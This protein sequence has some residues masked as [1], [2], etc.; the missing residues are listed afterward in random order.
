MA[1]R[2][3]PGFVFSSF[4]HV[5]VLGA[6]L[7]SFSSAPKLEE[8]QET[9][10]VEMLTADQF[11]QIMKGDKSAEKPMPKQK[12][13]KLAQVTETKP[14]PPVAEAKQDVPT[15]PPPLKRQVDPGRSDTPEKT[16]DAPAPPPRPTPE[17]PKPVAKTE[18]PKP[19][20]PKP[21]ARPEP[22]KPT[23]P[24][25]E[26]QPDPDDAEPIRP[27]PVPRPKVE[28]AKAEPTPAVKPAPRPPLKEV[29]APKVEARKPDAFK[30]DL[31]AK[32][33][34]EKPADKPVQKP[35]SRPKSGDETAEARRFDLADI[36]Q[37]LSKDIP[38]RRASSGRE[39]Q[40]VA[41]L[42]A[43]TASAAQMSPSLWAALDG[44]M[45]DQYKQCWTYFGLGAHG[46]YVPEIRVQYAQNGGLVGQP[47]LMNPPSDPNLRSL[48]DSAVR[49][50]R[51]CDPMKIPAQFMP[52]YEQWKGRVVRFDPETML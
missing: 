34:A 10:P 31:L 48:A 9:V 47:T 44:Y 24:V 52:Y 22:A 28:Q 18:P 51:K 27:K 32:L 15:P 36:S 1:L 19:E 7:V 3:D 42:G 37:L 5:A 4:T 30:P 6:A 33:L 35:A 21:T 50:V 26:K 29:P 41:S 17:P 38:Q 16:V 20:P 14:L 25:A 45:Q 46:R 12:A 8:A 40:Q 43:P 49:A 23:P 13:D 2:D 11:N 39:L